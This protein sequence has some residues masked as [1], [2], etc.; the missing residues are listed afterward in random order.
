MKCSTTKRTSIQQ[1]LVFLSV[2]MTLAVAVMYLS[3]SIYELNEIRLRNEAANSEG[4]IRAS[5]LRADDIRYVVEPAEFVFKL[6]EPAVQMT[7]SSEYA[8]E[9][10]E[11]VIEWMGSNWIFNS[12]EQLDNFVQNR[13]AHAL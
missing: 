10:A 6:A 3:T 7:E 11:Q 2:L 9:P 12:Q 8:V 5:I 1:H 13:N 4:Q